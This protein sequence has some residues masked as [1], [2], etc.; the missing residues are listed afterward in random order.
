VLRHLGKYDSGRYKK[1]I[2]EA[3][4]AY[5]E[6]KQIDLDIVQ[7]NV[8]F[9]YRQLWK[10]DGIKRKELYLGAIEIG[11][12]SCARHLKW[13]EKPIA[14]AVDEVKRERLSNVYQYGKTKSSPDKNQSAS[15]WIKFD[16]DAIE[17]LLRIYSNDNSIEREQVIVRKPPR[18][19][20]IYD[21][22]GD[23]KWENNRQ[24]VVR[25][26]HKKPFTEVKL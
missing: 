23:F 13:L 17:L 12:M 26:R 11:L 6:P 8:V 4:S 19:I 15:L 10:K 7:V 5:V 25:D 14:L 16:L 1:V 20:Y 2:I 21:L 24:I 22:L 18:E 9:D 3:S